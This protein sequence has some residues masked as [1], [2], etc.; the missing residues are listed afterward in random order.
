MVGNR[1]VSYGILVTWLPLA[2]SGPAW[3]QQNPVLD[4]SGFQQNR[5][6]FN[7]VS[8]EHIDTLS[9]NVILTF[10]D[11]ALPGNAGRVLR[12]QRTYNSKAASGGGVGIA[13][14]PLMITDSSLGLQGPYPPGIDPQEFP[15]LVSTADGGIQRLAWDTV[16]TLAVSKQFWRYDRVAQT[17]SMPDGVVCHYDGG[18]PVPGTPTLRR[19]TECEDQY[20]TFV[21]FS[22]P[23]NQTEITQ[24]L[25]SSDTR[26]ITYDFDG[27][28]VQSL[29]YGSRMWTYGAT[30]TPPVGPGWQY[31]YTGTLLT[32]VTTPRGGVIT[33]EYGTAS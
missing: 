23:P 31:A 15:V 17:L 1:L 25:G 16:G 13:G 12:F 18:P 14:I 33:Y 29:S 27:E 26:V 11:L 10:T 7:D 20:S 5:D 9:G 2:C 32:Q 19:V 24:R 3:A 30:V 4:V 22:Y 8:F 21:E 28:I 6:Y